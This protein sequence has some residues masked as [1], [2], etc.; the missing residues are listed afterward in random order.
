MPVIFKGNPGRVLAIKDPAVESRIRP[1]VKPEPSIGIEGEKSIITNVSVAQQTNHQFLHTLG[2]DIFIYV[3]GDRV[4]QISL[5]G[6]SFP[7]TCEAPGGEGGLEL[8][9]NWYKQ[10]K[11]SS[12]QDPVKI[13]IGQIT[14]TG[15]VQSVSTEVM[16]PKTWLSR[17]VLGVAIIPEKNDEGGNGGGG[18]GGGGNGGGGNGNGEGD[19]SGFTP[20]PIQQVAGQAELEALG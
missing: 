20:P 16:D 7:E 14:F 5:Q 19:P 12:R 13:A 2:N 8:L 1:L 18:N 15:F 6:L 11:L 3:F 17:Y 10:H 9:L 4:G